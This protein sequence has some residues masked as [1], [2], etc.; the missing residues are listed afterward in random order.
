[1]GRSEPVAA[2]FD[3]DGTLVD[4]EPLAGEAWRRALKP[5]GYAVTDEDLENTI[6]IP[7]ARTH[8]YLAERA[9]IPAAAALWPELSR[10]LFAL[11]DAQ[12][13]PFD[14]ALQAVKDLRQRGVAIA[15]AS[16]SPR[17]RL[18]RTLARARLQFEITI[19]G[20]EVERGKPAPDMF[21]LA[22]ERLG[23]TPARCV[24]IEDSP[25]GVAAGIAAGMPTLGVQRVPH[26]D[27]S[28]ADRIVE[29]V[30]ASDILGMLPEWIR[31]D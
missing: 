25:P 18:D 9:E 7:Y 16:S 31:A 13:E 12:L 24:V 30:T 2:V 14:D 1:V 8:A 26:T 29:T 27:L 15:V 22:A 20:D 17:E 3:C 28:A 10:E 23:V 6:G 4:S 5:Y 21:L 11:I 19:A